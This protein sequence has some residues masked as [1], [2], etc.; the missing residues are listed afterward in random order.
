MNMT[1]KIDD[2]TVLPSDSNNVY[3]TYLEFVKR[4]KSLNIKEME[5]RGWVDQSNT[6]NV[7]SVFKE[8]LTAQNKGTTLYR[9][10]ADSDNVAPLAWVSRVKQIANLYVGLNDNPDF[11]GLDKADLKQIAKM[12]ASLDAISDVQSILYE[13]GVIVIYEQALPGMKADGACFKLSTGHP[14]VALS[15]RYSRVDN[16]WFTLLHEL[17][18]VSLHYDQLDD[19]IIDDLDEADASLIEQQANQLALNSFIPRSAWRNCEPKFSRDSKDVITFA[20]RM[21]IHPAVV[22]GRL[23]HELGRYDLFTDIINETNVRGILFHD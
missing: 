14:V 1:H 12:S 20:K 21:E 15:L 18:H 11:E 17:A 2:F 5:R 4:K 19:V 8:F 3:Q 22:A 9:K 23:R 7:A 6:A 13:K 10:T 16:F